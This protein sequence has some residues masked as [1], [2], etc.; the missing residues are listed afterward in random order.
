[1]ARAGWCWDWPTMASVTPPVLG[2]NADLTS[3][4]ANNFSMTKDTTVFKNIAADVSSA[5]SS[6]LNDITNQ[7]LSQVWPLLTTISSNDP[8]VVGS[9]IRNGGV[10]TIFGEIDLNTMG[11]QH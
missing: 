8:N 5:N 6:G 7:Q 1:M 2:G 4:N 11:V 3:W 9:N 10:S